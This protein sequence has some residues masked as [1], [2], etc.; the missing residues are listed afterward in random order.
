MILI[1]TIEEK[2]AYDEEDYP[3]EDG[4]GFLTQNDPIG[5]RDLVWMMTNEGFRNP[6]SYPP[7]GSMFEWLSTDT[8]T[9]YRTG[10]HSYK[11]LHFSMKNHPRKAKYWRKAMKA[12]GIIK[13]C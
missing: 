11:T 7:S 6:S 12:A 9:D 8:E 3:S 1:H 10:E 13:Q 2:Y 5:F 4:G